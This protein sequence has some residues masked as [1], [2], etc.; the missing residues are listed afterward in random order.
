MKRNIFLDS[1]FEIIVLL[2]DELLNKERV[3]S[4][5]FFE[6]Q[7]NSEEEIP[8]EMNNF[9]LS[10]KQSYAN[11]KNQLSE[12]LILQEEQGGLEEDDNQDAILIKNAGLIILWPF[13]YRLFDKCGFIID[14]KFKDDESVQK[15]ILMMQYLVTGS[16]EFKEHELVLNKILCGV[17]KNS[18]V[19][20]E[21]EIDSV[22]LELCESLLSGVLKN[23]EKLSNSS[24][25][26]LRTT[27]LIREGI[28]S[29]NEE[30]DFNL[31]VIKGPFDMLIETIPW[32]IS[33]IQTT[34][35]KN[36][37]IV[38]WK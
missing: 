33:I 6:D 25:E 34:F 32:N 28:L 9:L 15:S 1:P 2:F 23:W 8:L 24:I 22:H 17:P 10:F 37:L 35:M 38:D 20:I 19:D 3:S 14:K 18:F 29:Q 4:K 26:T 11:F 21:L 13:F 5:V 7:L 27:F 31:N 30:L 12:E 36:R 16:T